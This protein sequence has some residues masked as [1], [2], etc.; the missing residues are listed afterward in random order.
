MGAGAN[1]QAAG[2]NA[3]QEMIQLLTTK[4]ARDL[5]LDMTMKD[6]EE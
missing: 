6:K 1:A 3:A 4:T 5:A 2:V